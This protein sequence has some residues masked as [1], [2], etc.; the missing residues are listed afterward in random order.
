[1]APEGYMYDD[2]EVDIGICLCVMLV[3]LRPGRQ[4]EP[5]NGL[6]AAALHRSRQLTARGGNPGH[7]IAS[8]FLSWTSMCQEIPIS[9]ETLGFCLY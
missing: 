8:D 2:S 3:H 9:L 6:R 4:V 7:M 1:M 5:R